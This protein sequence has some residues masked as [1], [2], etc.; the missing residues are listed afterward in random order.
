MLPKYK[1]VY[2]EIDSK[3]S[4]SRHKILV[5]TN[6]FRIKTQH[7]NSIDE[8]DICINY[9]NQFNWLYIYFTQTIRYGVFCTFVS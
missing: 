6:L 3:L 7:L 4:R 5:Y 8:Y 2:V 1:L 9:S